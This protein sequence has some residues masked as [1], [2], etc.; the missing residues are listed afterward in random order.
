MHSQVATGEQTPLT[1]DHA[2][3]TQMA[4][5]DPDVRM[6]LGAQVVEHEPWFAVAAPQLNPSVL[7]GAAG[8]PRHAACGHSSRC[9]SEPSGCRRA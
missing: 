5:R 8:L 4:L 2:P 7:A 6:K 3:L 1:D 9:N